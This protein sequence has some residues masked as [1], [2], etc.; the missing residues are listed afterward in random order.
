MFKMQGKG[1]L[2]D[3]AGPKKKVFVGDLGVVSKLGAVALFLGDLLLGPGPDAVF[4]GLDTRAGQGQGKIDGVF[5]VLCEMQRW[6]DAHQHTTG[7]MTKSWCRNPRS[8]LAVARRGLGL[9][10]LFLGMW[11]EGET[12]GCPRSD[13]GC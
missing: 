12:R 2:A 10:P 5:Q 3:P 6:R 4:P 1:R 9:C 11:N 13:L 8:L 7:S